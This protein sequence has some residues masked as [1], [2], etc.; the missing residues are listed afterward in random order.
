MTPFSGRLLPARPDLAAE[1]LRGKVAAARFVA[2]TRCS[3]RAA[4]LDLTLTPEPGA[5]L[6][7]QLLHGERFVVY[8]RRPDG[9]AW[10]QA[11]LDGYV[12]YVAASALGAAQS[13][14]QR[15]TALWSQVYPR[16]AVR[17]RVQSE[18]PFLAEVAIAGTTGAFARLRGGGHVPRA[19]LAPISGDFVD[20]A[21]RFVGAPYLWGGRSAR[22]IDCSAL[23]QLA[24]LAVGYAA[25]RDSDMQAALL[26][27]ELPARAALRRGDL[28]FWNGHAG[29]MR[30]RDTLIHAN[31][32]HMAVTAEPFAAVAARITAAGGGPV[33][34]R[35]RLTPE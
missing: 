35:R 13:P 23:I 26:G 11:E 6:A 15:V 22:G 5:E 19:H 33:I 2:G 21:A 16:P 27:A 29:I 30:D 20:Q 25:P 32:Y 10:G 18:L 3:V 7:T 4:L 8:E 31:A 34:A 1:H 24:L 28:V 9:L 14:G 17:A 12:G